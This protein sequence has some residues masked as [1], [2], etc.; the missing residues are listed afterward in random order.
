VSLQSIC[1]Q[2]AWLRLARLA[3]RLHHN[4]LLLMNI[5]VG[6]EGDIQHD[7]ESQVVGCGKDR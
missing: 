6:F 1:R 3:I 7:T 4:Q 5:S 2:K